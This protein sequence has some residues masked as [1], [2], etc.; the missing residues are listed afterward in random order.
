[1]ATTSSQKIIS[2]WVLISMLLVGQI[3]GTGSAEPT[4]V[5]TNAPGAT[6]EVDTAEFKV[7]MPLYR[8]RRNPQVLIPA[9][10]I[11]SLYVTADGV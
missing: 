6:T 10:K 3:L 4:Q 5:P 2:T 1:M 7:G 9:F 11:D 8:D